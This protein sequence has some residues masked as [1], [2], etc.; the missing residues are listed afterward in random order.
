MKLTS[1]E[2]LVGMLCVGLLSGA[3]Y[4]SVI[5]ARKWEAFKSAH[6]CVVTERQATYTTFGHDSKGHTITHR[7]PARTAWKCDDGVT[8]WR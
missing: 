7:H 8:Y 3:I 1:E 5:Q 4:I 2:F 6:K